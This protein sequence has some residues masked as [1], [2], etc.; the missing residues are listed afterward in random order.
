M[1]HRRLRCRTLRALRVRPSRFSACFLVL[2]ASRV[3]TCGWYAA[4]A[5][6]MRTCRWHIGL[7]LDLVV[8]LDDTAHWRIGFCDRTCIDIP[9][10]TA[11]ADTALVLLG[12]I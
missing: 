10:E 5:M 12:V 9:T 4:E 2:L 3:A 7:V 8:K 11:D 6:S 1:A